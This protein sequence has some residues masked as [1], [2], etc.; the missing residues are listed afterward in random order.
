MT[1]G[2]LSIIGGILMEFRSFAC[3]RWFA[4]VQRMLAAVLPA[5]AA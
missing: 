1:N 5:D 4:P 3:F 2:R